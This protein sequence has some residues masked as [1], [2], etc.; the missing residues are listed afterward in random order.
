MKRRS[1]FY[2]GFL[3]LVH[4]FALAQVTRGTISGTVKDETGA[5]L[6]GVSITIGHVD[7]GVIR[8]T[9]SSDEG[10]YFAPNLAIGNYQV[11]AELPGFSTA[12]RTGITL[13]VGRQAI[14]DLVLQVGAIT[15]EVTVT[16]EAPLVE[17]T[18]SSVGGLVERSQIEELPLSGRDFGEL[19]RLIAGVNRGGGGGSFQGGFTEGLSIR[20]SRDEAN[21]ILMDG[22]D[23]QGVDNQLPGSVAGVT[24]G[25]DAIQEFKVEVGTYSSEFGRALGGV[26]NVST[27]SGSNE[28]HGT[29]FEFLRNDNLDAADFFAAPGEK[30]EF[31]RNQ[32]GFSIGGPILSDQTFFFGSYE[33]LRDRLGTTSIDDVPLRDPSDPDTVIFTDDGTTITAKDIIKPYLA[34]YPFPNGR[35]HGDG[36]AELLTSAVQPTNE[37]FFTARIDHTLSDSDSLF[38]VYTF[39]D[40]RRTDFSD[41]NILRTPEKSR[42]QF[43][44]IEETKIFSPTVFN[45]FH[46]GYSRNY[47]S[48]DRAESD[49]TFDPDLTFAKGQTGVGGEGPLSIKDE[50]LAVSGLGD[51]GVAD[52]PRTWA[53]NKF[54]VSDQVLWKKGSHSLKLGLEVIRFHQNII[55]NSNVGGEYT[56]RSIERFLDA[57]PRRFRVRLPG[58]DQTRGIRT[59][60]IGWYLQDDFNVSPDLTLNLGFRHEIHTGP[61]EKFNRCP[62]IV[63]IFS[64]EATRDC[65]LFPTFNKNFGPRVGFAWDFSGTGKSAL[66][67][68]FG[69]FYSELSASSYYTSITNQPPLTQ[70][71]DVRNPVFPNAFQ[72]ILEEGEARLRGNPN[73][74][75]A[76]P[77][78]M[79]FSL[80]LQQ[81][82]LQNTVLSVGYAGTLGRHLIT[83]GEE[84]VAKWVI[85][86]AAPCPAGSPDGAKF[87]RNAADPD[88]DPEDDLLSP[89]WT[90]IRRVTTNVNSTYHGLLVELRRRFSGGFSLQGSYTLSKSIDGFPFTTG[91]GVMDFFDWKRDTTLSD[92]D[93][94]HNLTIATVFALPGPANGLAEKVLGGWQLAG[95]INLTSG[96]PFSAELDHNQSND[97]KGR[98]VERPNLVPGAD[99][100]PVLGGPD[101]YFD[102]L[103][104]ELQP[105]GFYGDLARN[106]LIGPGRNTLDFSLTKNMRFGEG[107]NLQFRTELFNAFNRP[108]FGQPSSTIFDEDGRLGK[109]GRIDSTS[110]TARQIQF[111]LKLYF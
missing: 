105:E 9:V 23:I 39:D 30:P 15:D 64:G 22:T 16:G 34:L 94:R 10:S 111:G 89:F 76:L 11:R 19:T 50:E 97:G 102:P 32:F 100:N 43:L 95:I 71:A 88:V 41:F 61:T 59:T 77:Y 13:T 96:S 27:R 54:Q 67:G 86:P 84:N 20:G 101:Q 17:S 36:T 25:I 78:T 37:D 44:T 42:N 6:P 35:D 12:V 1:I 49:I 14:V 103:A 74:Y 65:P 51:F 82:L 91:Q 45:T 70:I 28:F 60:Y 109:A 29:F 33:G 7:T 80:T 56:F 21:K 92:N 75:T 81:E 72:T 46:F 73:S 5:V 68:G 63:E 85:C 26:I 93:V 98:E 79:Q 55:Q 48:L 58:S 3:I 83:R 38:G 107:R 57:N 8:E 62:N 90:Q 69:I 31:K 53:T 40:G 66:R 52:K 108:N 2:F 110:A 106:S 24:L 87:F 18:T 99:N 104:F 4:Q 47:K